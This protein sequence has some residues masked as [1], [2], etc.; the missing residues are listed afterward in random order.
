MD[1]EL[2]L[3]A[4]YDLNSDGAVTRPIINVGEIII[5]Y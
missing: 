1:I 5:I 3:D 2:K 4:V